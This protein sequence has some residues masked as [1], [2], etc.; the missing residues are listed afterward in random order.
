MTY[1]SRERVAR[2]FAHQEADRVPFCT[3]GPEQ[4]LVDVIDSMNLEPDRRACYLEGDFKYIGFNS[5][6]DAENYRS[7]LPEL[8]DEAQITDWGVGQ[9][10]LYTAEGFDAGWKQWHPL[11]QVN[12]VQELEAYPWPDFTDPRRHGDL[13]ER[14]SAAKDDGYTVLGQNSMTIL[15]A[16]CE[17]RG[18][19][20]LMMDFYERPEY[21]EALF[22]KIAE[23]R[24][25]QARR[26]MEAGAD[27]LRIGDDIA[28]QESLIISPALYRE[29]IKPFHASV[30]AE[31]R[32]LR[33]DVPVMYH[34]DGNLTAL[35]SDLIDIGVTAVH[36][37]QPECMDLAM[38][39]REYGKDLVLCG[40]LPMQSVF[41][42][43][44]A[45][46]VRKHLRFL[47]K[48]IAPGGGMVV[49]F[50]GVLITPKLPD[51]ARVFYEE[52]YE[53]A[54]YSHDSKL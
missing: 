37:L 43:G 8:P 28:T 15:E 50:Y 42:S 19:E 7:Y 25:F 40:C 3:Y 23:R 20:Q 41:T 11:A 6:V 45:E 52:F 17:L 53:M 1:R 16:S 34:S 36:P 13:E 22:E 47:M 54:R 2:I 29:R 39:K 44:S 24:R 35:L 9:I 27:V 38:L 18:M 12:T 32:R 26:L 14:I 5:L 46:D 10:P 48:E 4:V 49:E 30:I 51:A 33:P 31:A 21:I